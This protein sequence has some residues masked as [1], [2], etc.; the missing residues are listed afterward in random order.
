MSTERT[1]GIIPAGTL[2]LILALAPPARGDIVSV[3]GDAQV[4]SVA[5]PLALAAIDFAVAEGEVITFS[6]EYDT[7]ETSGGAGTLVASGPSASMTVTQVF[8][9]EFDDY[10]SSGGWPVIDAYQAG[11]FATRN[12]IFSSIIVSLGDTEALLLSQGVAGYL[13]A[14]SDW[15]QRRFLVGIASADYPN[16][17]WGWMYKLEAEITSLSATVTFGPAC[18]GGGP[19][20]SDGDGV[21]DD[22]DA[23]PGTVSGEPVDADGCGVDDL[24]PCAGSLGGG[25]WRNHGDYMKAVVAA[26][27][28]MFDAGLITEDEKDALVGRAA[29]SGCGS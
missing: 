15:E 10:Q 25:A 8:A 20:D 3:Q 17:G 29:A 13:N 12:G 9:T 28:A 7:C 19:A 1:R 4:W 2:T 16:D 6:Y 22:A 18:G 5:D 24:V 27:R 11:G 23:C 14:L 26:V 21:T